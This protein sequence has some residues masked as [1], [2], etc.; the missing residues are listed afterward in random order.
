MKVTRTIGLQGKRIDTLLT[1]TVT[2]LEANSFDV[3][4]ILPA[5]RPF[6]KATKLPMGP[7]DCRASAS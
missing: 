3:A 1:H 7:D 2:M 4:T 6:A 5:A